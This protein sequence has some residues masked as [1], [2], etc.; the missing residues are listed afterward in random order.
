MFVVKENSAVCRP[1]TKPSVA[2]ERINLCRGY[3]EFEI[4]EL[5]FLEVW[6]VVKNKKIMI[7]A[8]EYAVSIQVHPRMDVNKS[9]WKDAPIRAGPGQEGELRQLCSPT[10]RKCTE[11]KGCNVCKDISHSY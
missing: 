9:F 4:T 2:A 6:Y 11:Q 1:K 5:K 10:D 8:G 7:M 3:H